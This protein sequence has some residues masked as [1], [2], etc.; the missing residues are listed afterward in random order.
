[1]KILVRVAL[2][3]LVLVLLAIGGLAIVL[4]GLVE[5][6]AVRER[7]ESAAND[8]LGREFSYSELSF[9]LLPPRLVVGGPQV[10]GATQGAPSFVEA[11]NV[12]LRLKV[13]P[14]LARTLVIDSLVVSGAP[15]RLVRTAAGF[16]LPT[17]PASE[18]GESEP[19][20]DPAAEG[21]GLALAVRELSLRNSRVI[22]EDRTVKPAVTWD[23]RDIQAT[24]RAESLDDPIAFTVDAELASGGRIRAE[25]NAALDASN[26]DVAVR[27]DA[28]VLDP[29]APYLGEGRV[30][31][32]L[33]GKLSARGP[34]SAIEQVGADLSLAD[35]DVAVAGVE[36]KGALAVTADFR[37]PLDRLEGPYTVDVTNA[38]LRYGDVFQK[39][40][41]EKG[42]MK[43]RLIPN[44]GGG[45]DSDFNVKLHNLDAEVK[46]RTGKRTRAT[47]QAKP[48]D[49]KGW[50]A[51]LPL[52]AGYGLSGRVAP[53]E[54]QVATEPMDI[55]GRITL[56]GIHAA[57][58]DG[59]G[60]FDLRGAIEGLGSV[61]RLDGLEVLTAG[62]VMKIDGEVQ[63][64]DREIPR[65][66]LSLGTDRASTNALLSS[67]TSVK[68]TVFGPLTLRS[69]LSG[70]LDDDPVQSLRGGLRFQIDEGR[71]K[72][73]SLLRDTMGTLATFGEAALLVAA[74]RGSS[75][76]GRLQRFYGDEFEQVSA[77]WNIQNG[78]A[79]TDDL[80]LA[81]RNYRV[82]LAGTLGLADQR[83]D[84]TG[85]MLINEEVDQALSEAASNGSATPARPKVIPL[86]GV[87]GTISNPKVD[88]SPRAVTGLVQSYTASRVRNKFQEKL[89]DEL[90]APLGEAA[91]DL[92]EGILGGGRR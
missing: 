47:V 65:Y 6:P 9:G 82:E 2:G 56:D 92:L 15:V 30:K 39:P 72:G 67:F 34:A 43:G 32:R 71:I 3:L 17:P 11:E 33:S 40:A 51:L 70:P 31:G 63:N 90:G 14:L 73:V 50:D 64:L 62:Q 66:R 76:A 81:Y 37:G 84:F 27:L 44:E 23:L 26:V 19:A 20:P 79:R 59:G 41:G 46:A 45:Y 7:I 86:A 87:T 91:G 88:L 29:V 75:K 58:P 48:F 69:D 35:A 60:E 4:P 89:D 49:L 80:L 28:F 10:A 42:E 38:A 16:D 24:G 55:R 61:V 1:M 25:G 22:V 85:R 21:E 54:L 18:G 36:L 83:L 77:T 13:G 12:S 52:L 78:I 68:D 53:G 57:L 74:V 8:A 5:S